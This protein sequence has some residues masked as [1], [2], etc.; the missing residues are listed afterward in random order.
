[1]VCLEEFF[2]QGDQEKVM[3]IPVPGAGGKRD[4]HITRSYVTHVKLYHQLVF[5]RY[6]WQYKAQHR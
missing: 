1:M 6:A 3:Q 2:A 4:V 5:Q